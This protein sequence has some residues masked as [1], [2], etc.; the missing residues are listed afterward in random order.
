M[1]KEAIIRLVFGIRGCGKTVKV[2]NLIK[3]VRRLIVID[4]TGEDYIDGV[5]F[6]SLAELKKFWLK[7]YSGDFRLIYK[8]PGNEYEIREDVGEICKLCEACQNLTLVIEELNLIFD[9]N[10]PPT[11]FNRMLLA[12]RKAGIDLI[13]V[14]QRP[15]GFGRKFTSQ[16]KEFYVFYSREPG[17]VRF[18]KQ[19]L[20]NEAALAICTLEQ[21]QYVKWVYADG[22]RNYEICK[23]E[24][25]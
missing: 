15:F 23:D 5:S 7:V 20:G 8:P 18:F 6:H 25:L 24:Y 1:D 2:R 11:E 4:T 16:A 13:G 22:V 21:Y 10:R 12:G 19:S 17:D 9:D 14:A 3:D